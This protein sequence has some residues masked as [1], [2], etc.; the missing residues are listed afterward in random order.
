[1]KV[2]SLER[3]NTSSWLFSNG[4]H[5]IYFNLAKFVPWLG[6]YSLIAVSCLLYPENELRTELHKS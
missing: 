1:M 3:K 5:F 6:A 4:A 2:A